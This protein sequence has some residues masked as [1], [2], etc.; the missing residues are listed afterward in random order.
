MKIV[1]ENQTYKVRNPDFLRFFRSICKYQG[2][3]MSMN[4]E[5]LFKLLEGESNFELK[6]ALF[7]PLKM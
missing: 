4:Q 6:K 1:Q 5:I 2:K 3:G 7:L